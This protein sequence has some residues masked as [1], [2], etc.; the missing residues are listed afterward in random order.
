[1]PA[2][3]TQVIRS[4]DALATLFHPSPVSSLIDYFA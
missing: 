1:L 4:R 2:T 3:G